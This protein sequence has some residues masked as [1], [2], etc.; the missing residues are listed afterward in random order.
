MH[1]S[2]LV[3]LLICGLTCLTVP[4]LAQE[5]AADSHESLLIGPGD[6]LRVTVLGEPD[7]SQKV[8]VRDSGEVTLPMIGN[9]Q[10]RGLSTV[11]ASA[12][13]AQKYVEGQFLKHPEI[14]V[15]VE[16][17]ATQSVSVLGQVA[18][19]GPVAIS[20]PRSLVD[21]IAMAGG[22]TDMADRHITVERG[23][24]SRGVAEIFLSNRAD[25]A[26]NANVEIFP[27]D[28]IL[29]PKAGVVYVLGDV[30]RPGGYLMQ[31]N[32]R[33]TVL[34]VLAMAA[35]VNKTASEARARLIHNSN[36]Q[37][38]ERDLPLKEIEQG[39]A[40]DELLEPDDVIFIPFSFGRN[41]LLGTN[42]IIA[43]TS[44]ALIYAGH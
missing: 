31:N 41:V 18:K 37:Y 43:A 4:L 6:L 16:E 30:G 27:G 15:F 44:S 40:P 39:K 22:L 11:D 7:L 5:P 29:V 12:A 13:I 17:Y 35:G 14:S 28:K 32:S 8:R 36:G 9:V 25:D 1:K 3:A 34:Q 21:V 33:I 19:P 2:C 38:Q 23:G 10:V 26:L 24:N 20:T 42:S